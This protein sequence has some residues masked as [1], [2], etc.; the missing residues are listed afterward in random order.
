[1]KRAPGPA[2]ADRRTAIACVASALVAGLVVVLESLLTSYPGPRAA[3]AWWISY[4]AFVGVLV[5]ATGLLPRP[6]WLPL[7]ILHVVL[8]ALAITT[9][10][11]YPDQGWT[12]VIVV[13]AAAAVARNATPRVVAALVI[14]QTAAVAIGTAA[15]GWPVSDVV[16]GAVTY[17]G[18]QTF[19]VFVVLAARREA[20]A[21]RD[22][23]ITHAELRS[24]VAVLESTSRD[25]ERLRIA[26]D[27]HDVAGHK[28]TA[29]AL[30][31]EVAHHS[32]EPTEHVERARGIT[33]DLLG[34]VRA[35]VG[36]LRQTRQ[37][38][39]PA[40]AALARHVPG[41]TVSVTVVEGG[42]VGPDQTGVILRWAQ[43]AITNTL[44]HARA[45]RLD[46][47]VE[48]G[49]SG[50]RLSAVDDGRGTG[51]IEPGHGLTGMRERLE[52]AGGSLTIASA[53]GAGFRLVGHL[54]GI[55]ATE[56]PT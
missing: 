31:L 41:L 19:A 15:A 44:R 47:T 22:L 11:L 8:A 17:A 16:L 55:T 52:A 53:P 27:L 21:R 50:I 32:P 7:P 36:E 46:L 33:K 56:V 25:S 39:K 5:V 45:R 51:R 6:R 10:L 3:V 9:F 18:F 4:G 37:P 20:E 30:E 38:L 28:L 29:L 13:V 1:M 24:A 54:P 43:E 12:A 26:R 40:L 2:M 49:P 34:D 48:A 35:A 23:A 14:V 42:Q